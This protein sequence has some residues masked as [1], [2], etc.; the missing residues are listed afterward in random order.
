MFAVRR[1]KFKTREVVLGAAV[2][3]QTRTSALGSCT[4]DVPGVFFALLNSGLKDASNDT[5][6]VATATI[7]A[8]LSAALILVCPCIHVRP[9]WGGKK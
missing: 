6:I 4:Y 1:V 3:L 7:F 5:K 8:C 2:R 9:S